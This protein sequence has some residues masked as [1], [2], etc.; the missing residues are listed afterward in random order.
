MILMKTKCHKLNINMT[1]QPWETSCRSETEWIVVLFLPAATVAYVQST[2]FYTQQSVTIIIQPSSHECWHKKKEREGITDYN[3]HKDYFSYMFTYGYINCFT[4]S[5]VENPT[6]L[7]S[8]LC[9]ERPSIKS[10]HCS[11]WIHW[12]LCIVAQRFNG[13]IN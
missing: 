13:I 3:L 6:N 4:H 10:S 7:S 9:V 11:W 2:C 1:T 5:P 8:L 12:R